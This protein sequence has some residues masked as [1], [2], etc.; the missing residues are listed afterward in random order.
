MAGLFIRPARV[1]AAARAAFSLGKG[2]ENGTSAP[3]QNQQIREIDVVHG[4]LLS[5]AANCL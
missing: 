1:L 2:L 4:Y 3:E 5:I